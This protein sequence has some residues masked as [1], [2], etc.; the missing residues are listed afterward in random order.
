MVEQVLVWNAV[1]ELKI[2]RRL[3]RKSHV[4]FLGCETSIAPLATTSS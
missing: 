3:A 2:A 1:T 4:K